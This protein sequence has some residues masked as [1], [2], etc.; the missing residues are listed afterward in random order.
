MTNSLLKLMRLRKNKYCTWMNGEENSM[1][2]K[3]T[4]VALG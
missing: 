4:W 2:N 3:K 1:S